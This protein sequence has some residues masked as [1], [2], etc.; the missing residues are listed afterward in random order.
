MMEGGIEEAAPI[1]GYGAEDR[2]YNLQDPPPNVLLFSTCGLQGKGGTNRP[3]TRVDHIS[4]IL[5]IRY[6]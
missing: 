6:L 4:D 5:H 1:K 2:M 3:F